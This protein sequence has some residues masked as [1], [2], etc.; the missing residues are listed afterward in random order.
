MTLQSWRNLLIAVV[1]AGLCYVIYNAIYDSGYQA[2][3]LKYEQKNN[4]RTLQQI[5]KKQGIEKKAYQSGLDAA[6]QKKEVV[7]VYV[8]IE[9][10]IIKVVSK[11]ADTG[12]NADFVSE[13]VRLHNRAAAPGELTAEAGRIINDPPTSAT[14]NTGSDRGATQ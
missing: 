12:C 4:A 7:T 3:A 8:P 11:P 14:G 6:A 9:K 2:A 13:W 1:I 5:D 10:E